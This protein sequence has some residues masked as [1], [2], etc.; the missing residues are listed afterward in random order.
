MAITNTNWPLFLGFPKAVLFKKY[1]REPKGSQLW[2]LGCPALKFLVARS[3]NLATCGTRAASSQPYSYM[4]NIYLLLQG[5]KLK[6]WSTRHLGEWPS[7]CTRPDN[8]SLAQ[9]PP[10][11]HKKTF[12]PLAPSPPPPLHNSYND[13]QAETLFL[14]RNLWLSIVSHWLVDS[15]VYFKV[16]SRKLCFNILNNIFWIW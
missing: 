16:E 15:V 3:Q 10:H 14:T 9:S 8:F 12:S 6:F 1:Y 11:T 5:W 13:H 2:K 4:T 7:S